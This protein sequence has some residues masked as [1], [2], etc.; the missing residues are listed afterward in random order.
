MCKK[1]L[2]AT[3]CLPVFIPVKGIIFI[4]EVVQSLYSFDLEVDQLYFV[5]SSS[6]K[7]LSDWSS[8]VIYT[9]SGCTSWD[10]FCVFAHAWI[11]SGY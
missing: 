5:L 6:L 2:I 1:Q 7:M 11:F 3:L 10:S 9:K 4:T 8:F